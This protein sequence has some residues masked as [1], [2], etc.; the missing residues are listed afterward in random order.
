MVAEFLFV[1]AL[2]ILLGA[3]AVRAAN[4]IGTPGLLLFLAMGLLLGPEGLGLEFADTELARDLGLAAA[5]LILAEGGLTARMSVVR[6]QLGKALI[7]STLGVLVSVFVVAAVVVSVTG[8]SWRTGLLLGAV[9]SS[10][11]AA[12]VFSVLRSIRLRP[13]P[14]AILEAESGF[15]D[16]MAVGL[17]AFF[18]SDAFDE[19]PWWQAGLDI[20]YELAIGAA[21][22]LAIGFAGRWLLPRV[23]LPAAGLYPLAV[24]SLAMGSYAAAL[25]LNASGFMSVYVTALLLGS[26][27]LPHR[28]TVLGFAEGI[29]WLAQIGLF[30]MLGI[31]VDPSEIPGVLGIGILVSIVLVLLARPLSVWLCLTPF[32]M[33]I[34]EQVFLSWGGL[35]GAVPIVFATIPLSLGT[36]DG[37]LAFT[38]TFVVVVLLTAIQGPT[39]PGVARRTGVASAEELGELSV[40]SAPLDEMRAALVE[41][42]VPSGSHLAGM[43]LVDLRLPVGSL[44]S[45]V[46]R[47]DE[48]I[49]PDEHLRLRSGDRVLIVA[50]ES[51]RAE[52][53]QRLREVSRGGRLA[54]WYQ[55]E[56]E[57][58]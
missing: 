16:A 42:D 11:D 49:V 33:P 20:S 35:R 58:D 10:T 28:R 48:S 43:Y 53:E 52:T 24:L 44:V 54:G 12:A 55:A 13:R 45:L 5:G 38:T 19:D 14:V 57:P 34:P 6:P 41:V 27:T 21:V 22:G 31:L 3:V 17:V 23:A 8:A 9:V 7:L 37:T 30:V 56:A 26:A 29:G 15:N 47:D 4:R 50:T 40:E 39:L 18:A 1:A 46:V 36:P 51:S 25:L 2:V 32:R